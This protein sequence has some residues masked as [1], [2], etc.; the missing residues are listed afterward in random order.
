MPIKTTGKAEQTKL[1]SAVIRTSSSGARVP[2]CF[3]SA[4]RSAAQPFK[5]SGPLPYR[6]RT[7]ARAPDQGYQDPSMFLMNS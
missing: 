6:E 7:Y 3:G 2:A 4:R 1:F 5:V